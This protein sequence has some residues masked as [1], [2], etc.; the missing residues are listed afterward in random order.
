M[1]NKCPGEISHL[2]ALREEKPDLFWAEFM[3]SCLTW[4][5]CLALVGVFVVPFAIQMVSG[6]KQIVEFITGF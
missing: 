3:S 2:R 5:V 4:I 1:L 6:W